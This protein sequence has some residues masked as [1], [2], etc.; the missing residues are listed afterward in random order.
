MQSEDRGAGGAT[1]EEAEGS[2]RDPSS[3]D[4][5]SGHVGTASGVTAESRASPTSGPPVEQALCSRRPDGDASPGPCCPAGSTGGRPVRRL[6]HYTLTVP[7]RSAAQAE[8]ACQ[9]LAPRIQ[10][11]PG[12]VSR[13]LVLSANFVIIRLTA[14]DPGQL[15]MAVN[16]CLRQ[17]CV[18]IWT[19]VNILRPVM[20]TKPSPEKRG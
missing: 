20:F 7:F 15:Q 3:S 5:S 19:L 18:L 10:R 14:E 1:G 13:Q 8:M 2:P 4:G 6:L 11:H 9:F 16:Y 12:A 17:L